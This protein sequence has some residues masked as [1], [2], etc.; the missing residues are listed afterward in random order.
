MKVVM[1]ILGV[2]AGLFGVAQLLQLLGVFGAGFTI[3]GIA[4]TVLGFAVS[5]ACFQKAFAQPRPEK[6]AA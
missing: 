2:L 1:I 6:D 3:P 4:F 5:A